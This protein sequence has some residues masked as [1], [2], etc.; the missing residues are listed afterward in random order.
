MSVPPGSTPLYQVV[1]EYADEQAKFISDFAPALEKMLSNGYS[2]S[3]LQS[4]PANGMSGYSCPF[5][6]KSDHQRSYVCT[7]N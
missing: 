3:D 4:A 6:I 5:Q 2:D 1:Q 7:F